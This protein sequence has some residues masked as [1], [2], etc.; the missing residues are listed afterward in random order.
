MGTFV[1]YVE[2]RTEPDDR[3]LELFNLPR[4]GLLSLETALAT[5]IHPDDRQ[6]YEA[7]VYAALQPDGPRELREEIRVVKEHGYR[8]VAVTARAFFEGDPPVPARL[9]GVAADVTARHDVEDRQAF[10]LGLADALRPLTDPLEIQARAV[11]ALGRQL[12]ASRALYLTVAHQPDSDYYVVDRDY[13]E[14]AVP[15]V[16]GRYRADDF[17]ATL[18]D[19][20]RAGRSIAVTDVATDPRLTD[21]ERLQYPAIQVRAYAAVPLV[22]DGVHV[23]LLNVQQVTP[24]YWTAAELALIEEV[25]ERTWAAVEQARA[26]QELRDS[27]LRFREVVEATPQ[28]VWVSRLDG[29]L[30][31]VNHN[32][33]AAIGVDTTSLNHREL[34]EAAVHPDERAQLGPG[35]QAARAAGW[36]FDGEMR[37]RAEDGGYRWFLV[38]IVPLKDANGA[39][40]EV[41]RGGDRHRRSATG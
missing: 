13:H 34:L 7:A 19:E 6:R 11:E 23:A 15:S 30:E 21:A 41:V 32:F 9:V 8:W 35:W 27:E 12:G 1:W 26:E 2:D 17:G 25:A 18:F 38:R 31:F 5:M 36:A 37:L 3:M 14:P 10:L 39:V 40:L 24:R 33:T 16:V 4:D 22:K 29:S 20:W 28:L